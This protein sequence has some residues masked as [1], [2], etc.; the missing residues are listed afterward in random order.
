MDASVDARKQL[1]EHALSFVRPVLYARVGNQTW[2]PGGELLSFTVVLPDGAPIVRVNDEVEFWSV[3]IAARSFEPEEEIW[4][5]DLITRPVAP[6]EGDLPYIAGVLTDSGWR[7]TFSL[8]RP[9]PQRL[10]YLD[11]AGEFVTAAESALNHGLIRPF[12][13]NAFYAVEHLARAELLSYS[14]TADEVIGA[15]KHTQIASVYHLW[16]RLGNTDR[17]FAGLLDRLGSA[18]RSATYLDSPLGWSQAEANETLSEVRQ[19]R[20]HVEKIARKGERPSK[21][22]VISTRAIEAGTLVA[23]GDATVRPARRRQR[24]VASQ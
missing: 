24:A 15:R 7:V 12:V 18:R 13:S 6:S 5:S 10:E 11:L 14:L 4:P 23:H 1:L 8:D 19:F 21:I 20:Q 3:P 22:Q 16:A 2:A 17:A 9:H